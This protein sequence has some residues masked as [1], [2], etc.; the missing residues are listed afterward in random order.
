MEMNGNGDFRKEKRRVKAYMG[1][2][3]KKIGDLCYARRVNFFFFLLSCLPAKEF[4]LHEIQEI[5]H[6]TCQ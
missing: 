5:A 6:T 1:N 3:W 2:P 4:A